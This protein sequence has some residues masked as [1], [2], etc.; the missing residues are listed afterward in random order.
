MRSF[1]TALLFLLLVVSAAAS[2][3]DVE[4]HIRFFK[5][6]DSRAD[7]TEG[8]R[9]AFEYIA[10]HLDDLNIF[11]DRQSLNNGERGH[12]FSENI[13]AEI[14]GTNPGRYILAAPVDSGAFSTAFLLEM[15]GKL[16]IN[17][18]RNT[19]ILAFLGAE[20]GDTR[21][22][23]YGSRR[24]SEQLNQEEKIF[25]VYLDSDEVPESWNIRI[26]G[27]GRIAPFW[28]TKT[29]AEVLSSEF[30]PYRLRG[31]DIQ[32]ARLGLQGDI[33]PLSAWLETE[34]PAILFEGS[35]VAADDERYRQIGRLIKAL[36]TIDYMLDEIPENRESTYIFLRPLSG[37]S[38]R[39]ISELPYI[40]VFL[41]V[42]ALLMF[43]ILLQS[44]DVRLNLRR[45]AR[46]W[47]TWPLLFIIVFLF[48]FLSTLII[49]E[50]ILLSDFPDIWSH[51]PGTFIFFKLTLAAAL[52]LNFI[53]ITRGLPLPRNPH[54]YSYAAI[55]TSGLASLIFMALD[56]TLAATSLWTIINL[57]ML[58][59]TRKERRKGFFLIL[60]IIPYII[61]LV[62]IIREPY[63]K[64]ISS[65][66]LTR[67]SGNL[68]ITLLLLPV[69]LTITS[70]NYW[71]LHYHRTRHSVLTPAATLTLSLSAVIT[72][73]WI[74][75]LNPFNAENPQPV[76]LIDYIDLKNGD[77][78]LEMVSPAP[79]GD[80]EFTLDG[81][82]YPLEN[83]GR[84]AE[85]RMP[86]NR[87]PLV[88][89]SKSRSFLGRRT[90][91]GTIS[92]EKDPKRL[93]ISLQS[94]SPF[95][96]HDSNFPFEMSSS[97]TA[98]EV[99]I[100]DNP[101]F[102]ITLRFTVNNDADLTL[103]IVGFWVNPEDPPSINRSDINDTA[104]RAARLETNL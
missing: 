67:I 14:P 35:G 61:G 27:D 43:I 30:I 56:I 80:A 45:F 99:F 73:F 53:L 79:I 100:G 84:Q 63:S 50:T 4:N 34:I 8:E 102:P 49:E 40:S 101:P 54:F 48:L 64:I 18:P 52:S 13:I 17:P 71:R 78:R 69:I 20:D 31:T 11:Y 62:V 92:G 75:S 33:G 47:W 66:L 90:I 39:I 42:T 38:P 24:A 9:A 77:R 70:L 103:S 94:A 41:T 37:M 93:V 76:E 3:S 2:P 51:A 32:V 25:A 97:G 5:A 1:L 12:S 10:G 74:V 98:A 104:T 82:V 91:S 55:T 96:L 29:V 81:N 60:S 15:A 16:T 6:L 95:T 44:R 68:V 58:T 36:S 89:E 72:L 88:I 65:M 26:G 19:I 57:L 7:G 22:H 23:P 46:Y 85:V 87:I 28:M 21:F 59:A 86:F 83:I